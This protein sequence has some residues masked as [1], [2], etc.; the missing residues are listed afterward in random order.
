MFRITRPRALAA[1]LVLVL[2]L[3][4]AA[5]AKK[6]AKD[7]SRL[8]PKAMEI[9]DKSCKAM[10]ALKEY[11]FKADIAL[12]KVFRDGSKVQYAREMNVAVRRPDAF[13]IV[14][15]GDDIQVSSIFDGAT[16]TLALP[17][18]KTYGQIPAALTI[19]ALIDHL[20]DAYGLE[21]PLGDMLVSQPCASFKM[22]GAAYVGKSVVGKTVC[23]HL[24]FQGTDVDWQIWVPESGDA[25][26][27]KLVITEKK[28]PRDPQ[29]QA[30][31]SEWK[32][33][34]IPAQTFA[35][36]A[37]EG[38]TRDDSPFAGPTGKGRK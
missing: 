4:C 35:F 9:L 22:T 3:P 14:T 18:S 36:T 12:D 30:V 21:S 16:F 11:S 33:E 38:F 26:P 23:D 28:L 2:A 19:D 20:A 13:R 10:S 32:Q 34:P 25:L 1:L 27:R 17:G 29:F 37:P 31:F 8:D 6:P 15:T 7:D 24:F 5:Q